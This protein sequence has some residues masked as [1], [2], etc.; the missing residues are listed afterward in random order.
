MELDDEVPLAKSSQIPL[1]EY[2]SSVRDDFHREKAVWTLAGLLFDKLDEEAYTG[3]PEDDTSAFEFRIRKDDLSKFWEQ[4]CQSQ[5]RDAVSVAPNAEERAIA[6]L[7]AHQ[8]VEACG[9]LA[10]GKDFRLAIL[11]SQIGGD[12]TMRE[13]MATQIHEWKEL[14]VLSEMTEPIRA[15][16]ELL[17]GKTCICEGKKGPLEDRARTFTISDRFKFDWK[18]AFGLRLWYAIQAADPIEAAVKQFLHDLNTEEPK[19][20]LPWFIEENAP[21]KWQDP[22]PDTRQDLLWGIL[23][24]YASSKGTTDAAPLA[25]I[26]SPHNATGNPL[27]ARLSFQLYQAL[28]LRFPQTDDIEADQLTWDFATQLESS[29]EWICAVFDVLHLTQADQ[30]KLSIESLISHHAAA[31]TDTEIETL[32]TE[33]KIPGSWIWAAK[34]LLARSLNDHFNEVQYLIRA[35]NW[36]EAHDVMCRTVAPQAIIEKDYTTLQTILEAFDDRVKV[37]HWEDAGQVYEEF[38]WLMLDLYDGEERMGCIADLLDHLPEMLEREKEFLAR[39]AVTEMQ[40]V[41]VGIAVEERCKVCSFITYH[42]EWE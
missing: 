2:A 22:A 3:L 6:H 33:F 1:K 20:P 16:Y 31:I 8:V 4:V 42:A 40:R 29:G 5:S 39:V 10:I 7:S 15:I 18:R 17:A 11:V 38:V 28:A 14:N 21:R 27:N 24:L 23:L 9:A 34:A 12:E 35:D 41:V 19:K 13:D 25:T 37:M 36:N 30:R 32:T 26:V